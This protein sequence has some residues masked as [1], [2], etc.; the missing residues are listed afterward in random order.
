MKWREGFSTPS[1][2]A[3]ASEVSRIMNWRMPDVS[4]ATPFGAVPL[5]TGARGRSG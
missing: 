2:A 1:L 4:I 3:G 5:R